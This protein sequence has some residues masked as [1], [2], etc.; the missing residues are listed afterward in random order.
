MASKKFRVFI[1]Q[2]IPDAGIEMLQND[3]EVSVYPSNSPIPRKILIEN[4]K[5]AV[6]VISLLSTPIDREIIDHAAALRVIS[7][8][9]VGYDNID[10]KY[11]TGRKIV[12]TNTPEV[13]TDATA[14]LTWA[15]LL[16]AARR[17]A[18]GDRMV[19]SGRFH[20][21]EPLMLLGQDLTKKTLGIIGAGRIGTAVALRSRGWDMRVLYFDRSRN[22][23]LE[24]K[25]AA[26][27][28]S[29]D[30]LLGES[31]FISIHLP[32]S[33]GTRHLINE[34]ALRRVKPTAY[35][36]NTSRGPI[37]DE[38]ALVKALQEKWIAGAALDVFENEPLLAPGL[39]DLEN[40][41]L[42]PHIGSAT[43]H[44]RDEMARTAARNLLAVLKGKKPGFAVN[45]ELFQD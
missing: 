38:T 41:T 24:E 45:P 20:G 44:T 32:L 23:L 17:L 6:G 16:A 43:V 3:C 1:T 36:V 13:L 7:N 21:W 33:S 42:V 35:L 14:D 15:L 28:V 9:A 2:P 25:L 31:D 12:V 30:T 4:I 27:K 8:Y 11:A 26:R 37:V 22:P 18:E 39:A 40:V 34:N 19:R 5:E 29:Q 10:V